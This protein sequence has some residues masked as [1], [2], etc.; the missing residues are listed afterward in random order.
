[1]R[2][3]L[4]WKDITSDI[5]IDFFHVNC[6]ISYQKYQIVYI[7]EQNVIYALNK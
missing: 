1:M 5:V 3:S 2:I 7:I 6:Q 4:F